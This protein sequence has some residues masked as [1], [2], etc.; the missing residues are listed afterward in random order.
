MQKTKEQEFYIQKTLK[1]WKNIASGVTD[2]INGESGI[3]ETMYCED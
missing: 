2:E 3:I 1:D